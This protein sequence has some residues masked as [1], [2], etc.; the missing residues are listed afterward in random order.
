MTSAAVVSPPIRLDAV[1]AGLP[2]VQEG[3]ATMT[4][5]DPSEFGVKDTCTCVE[6]T[7]DAVTF[8]PPAVIAA[9]APNVWPDDPDWEL[10]AQVWARLPTAPDA[11]AVGDR[12]L[13]KLSDAVCVAPGCAP[14]T[15]TISSSLPA[16]TQDCMVMPPPDSSSTPLYRS[17]LPVKFEA[18][19]IADRPGICSCP[20][21]SRYGMVSLRF[22][23]AVNP[24]AAQAAT[25]SEPLLSGSDW[26]AAVLGW[27]STMSERDTTPAGLTEKEPFC[28]AVVR[29]AATAGRAGAAMMANGA[30]SSSAVAVSSVRLCR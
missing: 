21:D 1:D 26:L 17:S 5:N 10:S 22:S 30:A 13:H 16:G 24:P 23:C 9:I 14:V 27:P 18:D 11:A 2:P 25:P 19:V 6:L 4:R 12:P 20:G 7:T 15:L 29:L 8:C 3:E 28:Q